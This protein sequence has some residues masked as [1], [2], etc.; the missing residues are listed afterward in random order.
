IPVGLS[1]LCFFLLTNTDI[2][3]VKHFF[4]PADAGYY[5]VAQ[6]IGK[7]VLF[8]PGAIG[9]VMFPKIVETHS[10]KMNTLVVLKKCLWAVGFLSGFAFLLSLLF[11]NIILNI[12]TGHSQPEAVSLVKYF[13]LSM[14]FFALVN[15][16]MIYHL[17]LHNMKFIYFM[18]FVSLLQLTAISLLHS[19]LEQVLIIMVLCSVLLFSTGLWMSKESA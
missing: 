15:I 19:S 4:S 7:I 10:K 8:V 1:T 17:S 5:S 9:V 14:T 18:L 3:L 12:L 11:P 16:L 2:I 13:A 6:T